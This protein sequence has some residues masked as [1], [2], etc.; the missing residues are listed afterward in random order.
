MKIGNVYYRVGCRDTLITIKMIDKAG[1]GY[2]L[3]ENDIA[4]TVN[5][6]QYTWILKKPPVDWSKPL[7]Y[8]NKLGTEI[9]LMLL[10]NKR[11][12]TYS[13]V[14]QSSDGMLYTFKPD[15][16]DA[17]GRPVYNPEEEIQ[18]IKKK[19]ETI[20]IAV[21]KSGQIRLAGSESEA[22]KRNPGAIAYHGIHA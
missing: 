17:D 15:G 14:C 8:E 5:M 1:I 20:W 10:T 9:E 22:K 19:T 7:L 4:H 6:N 11:A 3:S 21:Y 2:G 12:G 16:T 13:H 18:K